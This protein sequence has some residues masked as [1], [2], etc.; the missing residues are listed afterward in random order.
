MSVYT[1][2]YIYPITNEIPVWDSTRSRSVWLV[3]QVRKFGRDLM[4]FCRFLQIILHWKVFKFEHC[5]SFLVIVRAVKYIFE[6][7][8]PKNHPR[9]VVLRHS[10]MFQRRLIKYKIYTDRWMMHVGKWCP[11]FNQYKNYVP[12]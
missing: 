12:W 6:R 5:L 4:T 1:I 3:T 11:R 9:Q 8:I 2:S 10:F 7:Y